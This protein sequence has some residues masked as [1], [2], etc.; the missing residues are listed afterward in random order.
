MQRLRMWAVVL[1]GVGLAG[2]GLSPAFSAEHGGT[3]TV[4]PETKAPETKAPEAPALRPIVI[5]FSGE[6]VSIG[7]DNP[8]QPV[9]TVR[10]RYGVTKEM[11][12]EAASLEPLKPGDQVTVDY[13]YDVQTGKRAVQSIT[14]ADA[15]AA[16]PAPAQ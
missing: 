11:T 6:V 15:P 7:R 16:A 2:V 4:A 8:A 9:L 12:G 13:T 10:D 14:I 3:T 5:K 1:M